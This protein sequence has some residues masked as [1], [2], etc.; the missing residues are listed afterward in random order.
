MEEDR[1]LLVGIDLGK[2][3]T[4]MHCFDFTSYE[5]VPIGRKVQGERVYEIPTALAVNP[6]RGEWYWVDEEYAKRDGVI[7]L[8]YLLADVMREEIITVGRY[9]VESYQVLKRFIVK[10]LSLLKEYYP[11]EMIRKLVIT[12][13]KKEDRLTGYLIRI[14]EEIGIPKNGMVVQ[15]YRQSYMYYAISQPKELW[16]NNVGLFELNQNTLIYTQINIDRKTIPYIIG[17]ASR[18]ISD[19]ID[20]EGLER[21]GDSHIS[22]AF[23]NA[24]NT[25]LHKQLVT[26]V[27]VTGKGFEKSW[28]NHALQELCAG[29]RV[30][31]G[32]NL[33]TKGACYAAR[34]LSGE[35]KLDHC[36]LLDEEMIA[37]NVTIRLYGDASMQEVVLAKAG[38]LWSEIDSSVDV[39][40]DDEDEMQITIQDVL[41]H[42]TKAHMLSL[43]G[44]AGRENKMTRFT[45]RI[46]FVDS[47]TCI[48]TLKD[49]GFGEFCPS[50]NRVWE[51]YITV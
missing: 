19:G 2:E 37:C 11:A 1:K 25:A 4:Q 9:S 3:V 39:I 18:D 38:S 16:N 7:C 14:C 8:H 27:Y 48:V 51:R 45:I 21:D 29:R 50:S 42:E 6:E 17:A 15:N 13:S 12:V 32:Q 43:S 5:P 35:G 36:L 47:H 20:W 22:Y 34:E 10:V 23:I 44:F 46:R 49:N 26:T 30:F 24:A 41:K 40:P 28:A 33:F 31:R